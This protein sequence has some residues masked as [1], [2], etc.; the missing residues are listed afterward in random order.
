[1]VLKALH[2]S[3]HEI[4]NLPG[5]NNSVILEEFAT[6]CQVIVN[7][8]DPQRFV[9]CEDI[10]TKALSLTEFFHKTKLIL[11]NYNIDPNES[12]DNVVP[13][14]F[15]E[16]SNRPQVS[17]AFLL[18]TQKDASIMSKILL[19]DASAVYASYITNGNGKVGTI[20]NCML[21]LQLNLRIGKGMQI[22]QAIIPTTT[23]LILPN[24]NFTVV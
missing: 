10:A 20:E 12:F 8:D 22:L 2:V 3:C 19:Y 5:A 14:L 24:L 1:M 23:C 4:V 15:R 11:A 16:Y 17:G 9:I 6:R 13:K 7:T 18:T 21:R